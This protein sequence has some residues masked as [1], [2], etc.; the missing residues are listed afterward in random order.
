MNKIWIFKVLIIE[1]N[2]NQPLGSHVQVTQEFVG[3]DVGL[4]SQLG[5]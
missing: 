1:V 4:G 2:Q 3:I 5:E